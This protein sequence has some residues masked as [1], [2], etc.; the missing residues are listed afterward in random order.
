MLRDASASFGYRIPSRDRQS[1][2]ENRL[3]L[4]QCRQGLAAA[5]QAEC[6]PSTRTKNKDFETSAN[7]L[8]FAHR[9]YES[10]LERDF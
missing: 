1:Q 10:L 4:S 2:P 6:L 5:L 8:L 3:R 9:M 7:C